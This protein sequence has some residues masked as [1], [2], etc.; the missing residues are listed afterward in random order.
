MLYT[1]KDGRAETLARRSIAAA[2][3][4]DAVVWRRLFE[5]PIFTVG[6]EGAWDHGGVAVP[7]LTATDGAWLLHYYGWSDDTFAEHPQRGIGCAVSADRD[8]RRFRRVQW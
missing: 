2:V 6:R 7:R 8:L 5:T 1:A 4:S 3:S